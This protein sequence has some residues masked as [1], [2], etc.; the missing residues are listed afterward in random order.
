MEIVLIILGAIISIVG[1]VGCIIPALPGPPLNFIALLI[2]GAAKHWQPFDSKFIFIMLAITI[3]VTALDYV[4]P[5]MGA[6][7]YGATK[8]GIWG[9]IL[10][11][12]VGMIFFP[13]FGLIV[14][15]FVGAIIGEM[16]IGKQSSDA[17]KAGWGTFIGS[18]LGILLK[19]TASGVMT[20]Y[21]F[22]AVF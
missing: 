16:I 21:Y 10:G 18:I 12:I 7:K 8:A 15:T 17:I 11:M 9:S 1:I 14:G 2:I 13:P 20:F 22:K 19:V 3:V 5:I 6:K 4:I